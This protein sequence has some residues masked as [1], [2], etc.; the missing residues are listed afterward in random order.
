MSFIDTIKEANIDQAEMVRDLIS[1]CN[2]NSHAY[3]TKGINAVAA[4]LIDKYQKSFAEKI[5]VEKV[6]VG[7]H[8]VIN[9]KAELEEHALGEIVFIRKDSNKA[10]YKVMLMGHL[11]TVFPENC[12]FQ[13]C[14]DG[15]GRGRYPG[16]GLQASF[17]QAGRG[18][19]P[20]PVRAPGIQ[21][22]DREDR[23]AHEGTQEEKL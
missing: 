3:N 10:K 20:Q 19:S 13:E 11:D 4:F 21:G 9:D 15:R 16:C 5:S 1:V 17:R 8:L 22:G 14:R 6:Q 2:I 7:K 12:A 23:G 18:E